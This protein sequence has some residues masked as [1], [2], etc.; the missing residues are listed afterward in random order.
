MQFDVGRL[1]SQFDQGGEHLIYQSAENADRFFKVTHPGQA[2]LCLAVKNIGGESHVAQ[3]SS[4]PLNYLRRFVLVNEIF[5][6]S[7]C[8]EGVIDGDQPSMV[9]SQP[10]LEGELPEAADINAT[11]K[12]LGFHR[13]DLLMWF[14]PEDGIALGDTKRANFIQTPD[15]TVLAIDVLVQEATAEMAAAWGF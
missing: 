11:L 1:G 3:T 5:S 7:V 10:K 12:Q 6:D 8:F 2:G 4:T 9:I 15:G 13:T 14:R